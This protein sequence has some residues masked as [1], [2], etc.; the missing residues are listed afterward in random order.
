VR[1]FS[2]MSDW[3][4]ELES[5]VSPERRVFEP[6][7]ISGLHRSHDSVGHRMDEKHGHVR[8]FIDKAVVE[9]LP[10]MLV[11]GLAVQSK[12]LGT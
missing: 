7:C 2:S 11:K 5:R 3:D 8:L 12:K 6:S 9:P 1:E 10:I 4:L